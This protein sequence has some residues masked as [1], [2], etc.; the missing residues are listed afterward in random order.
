[1]KFVQ[2]MLMFCPFMSI[3]GTAPLN[4][5]VQIKFDYIFSA[6]SLDAL[7]RPQSLKK[8]LTVS[9]VGHSKFESTT[10]TC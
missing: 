9:K 2:I 7:R 5:L 6:S 10:Q 3:L 8:S 1:M 4:E